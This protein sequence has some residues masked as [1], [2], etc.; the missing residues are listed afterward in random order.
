M[1]PIDFIT[2][3]KNKETRKEKVYF[4]FLY[5]KSKNI[6]KTQMYLQE[7]VGLTDE[8]LEKEILDYYKFESKNYEN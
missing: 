4:L 1:K 5:F 7:M 8:E 6:T 2:T 3:A